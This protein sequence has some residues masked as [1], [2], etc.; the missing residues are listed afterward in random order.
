MLGAGEMPIVDDVSAKFI[1]PF[2]RALSWTGH[3]NVADQGR[4]SALE[5]HQRVAAHFQW[6]L[7]TSVG[8]GSKP[9]HNTAGMEG[10]QCTGGTEQ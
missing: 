5:P 9:Q 4:P 6:M 1:P 2:S 7:I 8:R 3:G 10:R